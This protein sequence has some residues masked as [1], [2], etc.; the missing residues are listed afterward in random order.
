MQPFCKKPLHYKGSIF[1]RVIKEFMIQGG[2]FTNFNGTGGVSIYGEK[3]EDENFEIDHT[4]P[5]QLSMAN[6][7]PNTNGSQFFITTF[8]CGHLNGKHVVFGQVVKGMDVV[9]EIERQP[10]NDQDNPKARVEIA[11]CG[12]LKEGESDGIEEDP[13]DP[14]PS[15]PQD[16]VD[17]QFD[18]TVSYVFRLVVVVVLPVAVAC[19]VLCVP[20]LSS[21]FLTLC[22]FVHTLFAFV[23]HPHRSPR[24]L[25]RERRFVVS[26]TTSIKRKS[27]KR[28]VGTNQ[29]LS[30]S[31]L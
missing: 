21:V 13:N 10:K 17:D 6:A 25:K 30:L 8:Q 12:E 14:Y 5:G 4:R 29:G 27:L 11:D 19:C 2:D 15:S 23:F 31:P 22:L 20:L 9:R 16:Y 28:Y 18:L 7:G 26:E 24:S 1:H 3:F